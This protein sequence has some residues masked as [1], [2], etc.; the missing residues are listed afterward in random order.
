MRPGERAAECPLGGGGGMG[1]GRGSSNEDE[2]DAEDEEDGSTWKVGEGHGEKKE[3]LRR[4]AKSGIGR[5]GIGRLGRESVLD[6][7]R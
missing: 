4:M 7:W 5:S 1:G 2:E 3:A 6:G